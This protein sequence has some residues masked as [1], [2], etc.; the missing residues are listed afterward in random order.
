MLAYGQA[1]LAGEMLEA[2]NHKAGAGLRGVFCVCCDL[3][4]ALAAHM[5]AMRRRKFLAVA[6]GAAAAS[7]AGAHAAAKETPAKAKAAVTVY[8]AKKIITM[9][10]HQPVAEA[11][12]VENGRIVAV[13]SLAAVKAA[14]GSRAFSIDERFRGKIVMPGLIEQH[15]H[16]IL[17]ALAIKSE[18]IANDAWVLPDRMVEAAT[19]PEAYR[20]RLTDAVHAAGDGREFLF[21]WGYHPYWHGEL[22]RAALDAM[23]NIGRPSDN[24]GWLYRRGSRVR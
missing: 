10:P 6:A 22:S 11:V 13:G 18:I 12:A 4:A 16:P 1:K 2:A 9:E 19:T 3:N 23:N 8:A 21:S 17:A 7:A 14:L 5:P 24:I 20:K 15:L